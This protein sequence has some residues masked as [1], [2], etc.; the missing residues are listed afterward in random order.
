MVDGSSSGGSVA[1]DKSLKGKS[2]VA[3]FII[4]K[5]ETIKQTLENE[6]AI[7]RE[8]KTRIKLNKFDPDYPA[9]VIKYCNSDADIKSIMHTVMRKLPT[10]ANDILKLTA[11]AVEFTFFVFKHAAKE[12]KKLYPEK[13]QQFLAGSVNDDIF[14]ILSSYVIEHK[15]TRLAKILWLSL[16]ILQFL[17]LYRGIQSQQTFFKQLAM[18]ISRYLEKLELVYS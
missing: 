3:N 18:K 2:A 15:Y 17:I 13:Y 4:Q 14:D 1:I 7:L 16:D 8:L 9:E 5:Y 12:L 11:M 6:F 10:T